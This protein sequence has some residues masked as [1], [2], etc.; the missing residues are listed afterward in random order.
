MC[1][2]PMTRLANFAAG[3]AAVSVVIE[4]VEVALGG[5]VTKP[6]AIFWLSILLLWIGIATAYKNLWDR[7]DKL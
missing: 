4:I 6:I 2:P 3:V 7:R 5:H 1:W